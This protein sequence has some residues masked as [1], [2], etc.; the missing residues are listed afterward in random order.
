[1]PLIQTATDFLPLED[2]VNSPGLRLG[3]TKPKGG[4]KETVLIASVEVASSTSES[5]STSSPISE[6]DDLNPPSYQQSL[7]P[8][9]EKSQQPS[10][11]LIAN[12]APPSTSSN[13][14]SPVQTALAVLEVL[15]TY[16]LHSD[17]TNSPWSDLA[18]F[19]PR[20]AIQIEANQ[21]I[22]LLL[23]GFPFKSPNAADKVLGGLPDLGEK[24]ALSHLQSLCENVKGVYDKGAEVWICSDGL[25]Y[26]GMMRL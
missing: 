18:G 26:N 21:S 12:V 11:S 1:M 9:T 4:E 7:E 13:S 5:G 17:L 15:E 6:K 2:Q 24:L 25:V 14:I 19:V 8:A 22:R 3:N 23:P 16:A 10:E 20:L